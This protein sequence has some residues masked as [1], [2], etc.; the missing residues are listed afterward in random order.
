[1]LFYGE[2]RG[3]GLMTTEKGKRPEVWLERG[4]GTRNEGME[5]YLLLGND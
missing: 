3:L 4:L 5:R 1:M 2:W